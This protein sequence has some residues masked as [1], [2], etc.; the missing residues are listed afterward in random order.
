MEI[1]VLIDE[2]KLLDQ[3][4]DS[5]HDRL[6]LLS[7]QCLVLFL[8]LISQYKETDLQLTLT[9]YPNPPPFPSHRLELY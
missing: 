9:H 4:P 2:P 8:L 6:L 7:A 1:F 5:D 3:E